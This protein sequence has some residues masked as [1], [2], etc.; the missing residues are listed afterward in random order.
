MSFWLIRKD[1]A[2]RPGV[3]KAIWIPT[4]W[5]GILASRPVS[6]WLG[7]GGGTEAAEGS[8]MDRMFYLVMICAALF[9][10]SK[11]RL[12][13]GL[14]FARNWPIFLFYGYL[15]LTIL[16]AESTAVAFKR[17]FKEF[18]NIFVA[19]VI[20]TESNP[21]QA[22][23]A[24]FVRCAILLLP[25][26]IVF[27]R[28]IP[29]LGR[30]YSV[31]GGMQVVGVSVQKNSLGLLVM[32]TGLVLVWDWLE[33]TRPGSARQNWTE[34][35][36]PI[37]LL[38]IGAY[39]LRISDSKTSTLCLGLGGSLLAS[40]RIP[41]I[42]QKVSAFGGYVLAGGIA[43]LALDSMIGITQFIVQSLGRDMTFTGRTDI[44]RELLKAGTDPI[45]GAGFC[46]FWTDMSYQSKL[47]YWIGGAAHN[48]YLEMYLD[49]GWVCIFFLALMLLVTGRRTNKGL[50]IGTNYDLLRFGVFVVTLVVNFSESMFARMSPIGFFF[51]LI[52]MEPETVGM[53][54]D[55]EGDFELREEDVEMVETTAIQ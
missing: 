40:S 8:P 43:F 23:R 21:L 37:G 2:L 25:L 47:P 48:G 50:Q 39:L 46:S 54:R 10:L 17:W 19:L 24:V 9:V 22:F 44:W 35:F 31:H 42:R 32:T 16:W 53:Q 27:V 20:L 34:R 13:W 41:F 36:L 26:S 14:I 3:S 12:N 28:Y 49:G 45:L 1:I 11:R 38:V 29:E 33:R 18:G 52:A 4:F 5:F 6:M 55:Y 51:L 7:W 15:L 30:Y